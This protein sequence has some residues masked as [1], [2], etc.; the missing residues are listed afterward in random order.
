MNG[1]LRQWDKQKM[2]LQKQKKEAVLKE[3]PYEATITS[4]KG[5]PE[6][7]T[8]KKLIFGFKVGGYEKE[9]PYDVAPASMAPGKPLRKFVEMALD[10]ALKDEEAEDL[11]FD[12]LLNR[13]CQIVVAHR[14]GAGGRQLIPQV[15]VVLPSQTVANPAA[16]AT[17][18]A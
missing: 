9:I 4:I 5:K 13:P 14:T 7:E 11:E 18:A 17:A 8:P 1:K 12:I 2:K 10:R 6:G 16:Q 3:G 15:T